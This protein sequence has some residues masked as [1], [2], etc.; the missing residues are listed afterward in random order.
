MKAL[1][2]FR[3]IAV[4]MILTLL[5]PPL[6]ISS[7]A[8]E[9]SGTWRGKWWNYYE[10]GLGYS[11]KG[12]WGKALK[13]FANAIDLREHDQRRART[14]GMHFTDYLPH[15][16]LGVA[17][18]H[19]GDFSGALRELELSSGSVKTDKTNKYLDRV[20]KALLSGVS[21]KKIA[22]PR[23][24]LS[25][26]ANGILVRERSIRLVGKA[27]GEGFVSALS[28]NGSSFMIDKGEKE[29]SFSREIQLE[30]GS[31]VISVSVEDLAGNK[32]EATVT[33]IAKR[34]GPGVTLSEVVPEERDG[35]RFVK[36]SG[37]ISDS[38]GIRKIMVGSQTVDTKD[39]TRY[40][41][42]IAVE[43][44]GDSSSYLVR[45]F[46][47]LGNETV[48]PIDLTQIIR[49]EKNEADEVAVRQREDLERAARENDAR[50]Q[51]ARRMEQEKHQADK[52]AL[53]K[54]EAERLA[55]ETAERLRSAQELVAQQ[56]LVHERA[57][58]ERLVREK[59]E[60][61]RLEQIKRQADKVALE[62][63]EAERLARETAERLRSAQELA[64]QQKLALE[65]AEA[66]RRVLE[67]AENERLARIQAEQDRLE[68]EKV[69]K[70][71]LAAE[72]REMERLAKERIEQERLAREKAEEE[73]ISVVRAE[74]E[75]L[76][77]E[78]AELE[79]LAR[80]KV[81][82]EQRAQEK[83][84]TERRAREEA[85]RIRIAR[86]KIEQERLASEIARA[87][88]DA[89]D[90]IEQ[91]KQAELRAEQERILRQK[92]EAERV[93]HEQQVARDKI[94]QQKQ[95]ELR[96]EQERLLRQKAEADR[97][98][99]EQQ[100]AREKSEL[101]KRQR[102]QA[103]A[104]QTERQKLEKLN[105]ALDTASNTQRAPRVLTSGE[106]T[107]P[108]QPAITPPPK[109]FSPPI[110]ASE[111]GC[112]PLKSDRE[113]P[114]ITIKGLNAIPLVFV[115]AFPLD[116]E[117]SD[118]CRVERLLI[119]GRPI[120]INKGKK[121][122]FSKV[123]RIESGENSIKIEAFDAAGNKSTNTV[124]VTRKLPSV[125]QNGS[126]M[127]LVVLPFDFNRTAGSVIALASDYL[128][129]AITEQ[130][131]FLVAERQKLKNILEEQN[132]N[133]AVIEDT[134][135]TAQLG[136]IMAAEA[137]VST[138]VRETDHS[139]EITSRIINSET[140]EV[141]EVLDAYT[142]DK[143]A[144]AVKELMAGLAAK[145]A[146]VFP[147]AEGIVISQ[148]DDQVTTD[149]GTGSHIRNRHGAIFYRKGKEIIH[150]TSGKSLG[151]DSL[152]LGEGYIE[153]V[154]EGFSKVRVADRY[155]DVKI[156][157]SDLVV[158]K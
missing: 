130:K 113:N 123:V 100:A 72:K 143:S 70:Q 120:S 106:A 48:A 53:E 141:M 37:D 64:A 3:I 136:K 144:L 14:Y 46:D 76:A 39:A 118:N 119:N 16:E 38:A 8:A 90:K 132:F 41:L 127:S 83:A 110:V 11:D 19:L 27:S 66:E 156:N 134:E 121:I 85:E 124:I 1:R 153:E 33:V 56:K 25:A 112:M 71:R 15:R 108:Y 63:S 13:D 23:I 150:P 65:R 101:E 31:N 55:H 69:E 128:T 88:K 35:K 81:V 74:Q 34:D 82:A 98:A 4:F 58:A 43:R 32:S 97:V 61:E 9:N 18:F 92:A 42:D 21:D 138:N 36:V 84:E 93:A 105:K 87:E 20:R 49:A 126:R 149:L 45:A 68:R 117:I 75:R 155:R 129:G 94:E 104:I 157:P 5:A 95:A 114:I 86:E 40:R 91:Q 73:R 109:T 107:R 51:A 151:R 133:Q 80:L 10:R 54:S 142:E 59:A 125:M 26:P 6:T 52:V 146:R 145:I 99:Q 122:Y 44:S 28:I 131:R 79:K 50:E 17:Y 77:Q 96:T 62:K 2:A 148:D 158:T 30:D 135:R 147:V 154:Q 139:L 57:E 12:E 60:N 103:S 29:I 47:V 102:E 89:R 140:A 116:G 111:K 24:V 78:R 152:M 22:P 137:I 67:K 7:L 115:D